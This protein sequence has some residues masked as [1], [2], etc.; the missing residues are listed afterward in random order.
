MVLYLAYTV[1]SVCIIAIHVAVKRLRTP[2]GKLF[3]FQNLA[4]P[5]SGISVMC[6][7]ITQFQITLSSLVLCYTFTMAF[8]LSGVSGEILGSCILINIVYTMHLGNKLI[9]SCEEDS[10]HRLRSYIISSLG[11]LVLTMFFVISYDTVT[12]NYKGLLLPNGHCVLP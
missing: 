8:I 7:L 1:V 12:K 9:P 6:L 11:M 5:C 10:K 3:M 4:A 2:F